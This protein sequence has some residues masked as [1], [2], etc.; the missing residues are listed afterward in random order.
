MKCFVVSHWIPTGSGERV[1]LI[2][3]R[4]LDASRWD[5]T[6]LAAHAAE[7]RALAEAGLHEWAAALDREDRG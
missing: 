1:A 3:V 5:F 4:R 6:R 2:V 7:D